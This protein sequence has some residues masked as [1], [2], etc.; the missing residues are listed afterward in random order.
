MKRIRSKIINDVEVYVD[1]LL[2]DFDAKLFNYYV[3]VVGATNL[4]G[5]ECYTKEE[6]EAAWLASIDYADSLDAGDVFDRFGNRIEN[7]FG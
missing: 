6:M 3:G 1:K 2:V 7:R 4:L 5:H